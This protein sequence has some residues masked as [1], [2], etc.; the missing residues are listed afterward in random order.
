MPSPV[1][2]TL[3]AGTLQVPEEQETPESSKTPGLSSVFLHSPR[4]KHKLEAG[5]H[6]LSF[7]KERNGNSLPQILEEGEK[8]ESY[9]CSGGQSF[10]L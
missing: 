2:S 10:S 6:S 4:K 7:L 1:G 5:R 9:L 3:P 8:D